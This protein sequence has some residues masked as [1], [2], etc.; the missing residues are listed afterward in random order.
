MQNDRQNHWLAEQFE[1]NR[2]HLRAVAYRMLGSA[3]EAWQ[4][5]NICKTTIKSA[6][7]RGRLRRS[8]FCAIHPAACRDE[9]IIDCGV[10]AGPVCSLR[11]TNISIAHA[12]QGCVRLCYRRHLYLPCPMDCRPEFHSVGMVPL[13]SNVVGTLLEP[14]GSP[15]RLNGQLTDGTI[16]RS[17]VRSATPIPDSKRAGPSESA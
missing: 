10:S 7:P 9:C 5:Q 1:E 11:K 6:S 13:Q 17:V 12:E 16:A 2:G 3:S 4:I 8:A 14:T 15:G